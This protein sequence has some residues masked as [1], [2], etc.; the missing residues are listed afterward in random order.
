MNLYSAL[1]YIKPFISKAL[2]CDPC[3]TRG[4][5]DHSFT[6]TRTTPAFTHQP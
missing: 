5:Q 3:V 1:L 2:R 6:H 4:S